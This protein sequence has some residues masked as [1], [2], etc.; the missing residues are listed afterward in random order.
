MAVLCPECEGALDVVAD[1]VEEGQ[2]IICDDCGASIEVVSAEPLE[3]AVV[4]EGEYDEEYDR[5][6]AGED[7][8]A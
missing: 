1:E 3:L 2:T 8:E 7:E 4:D 5:G 6:S